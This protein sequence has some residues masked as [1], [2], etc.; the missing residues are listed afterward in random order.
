MSELHRVY[1][2]VFKEVNLSSEKVELLSNKSLKDFDKMLADMNKV[3][4]AVFKNK[5]AIKDALPGLETNAKSKRIK[6]QTYIDEANKLINDIKALGLE[7]PKMLTDGMEQ[8]RVAID[9]AT[10]DEKLANTIK[11]LL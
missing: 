3:S 10:K 7:V 6:S 5:K 11:G 1:G 9:Q 4:D 8:S 2:Q